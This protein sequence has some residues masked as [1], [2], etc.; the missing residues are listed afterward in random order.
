MGELPIQKE[1]ARRVKNRVVWF[2]LADEKLYK[3]GFTSGGGLL[4]EVGRNRAVRYNNRCQC[5]PVPVEGRGV[6]I[7]HTLSHHCRQREII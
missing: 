7:P 6:P 3:R 1:E 4:H 2:V 5:N